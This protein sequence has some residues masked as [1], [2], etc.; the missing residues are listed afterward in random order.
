MKDDSRIDGRRQ[1]RRDKPYQLVQIHEDLRNT[2]SRNKWCIKTCIEKEWE[3]RERSRVWWTAPIRRNKARWSERIR[4]ETKQMT[5]NISI[6]KNQ[7]KR[8]DRGDLTSALIAWKP[9]MT[10]ISSLSLSPSRAMGCFEFWEEDDFPSKNGQQK[11]IRVG[12]TLR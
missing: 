12:P 10:L 3:K 4:R 6:K 9:Q 11:R 7:K 1:L 8:E 5:R 2:R